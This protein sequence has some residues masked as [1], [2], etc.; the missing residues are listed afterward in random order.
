MIANHV[1]NNHLKKIIRDVANFISNSSEVPE[2]LLYDFINEVRVS[3]LIVPANIEGDYMNFKHLTL[4]DGSDII[5]LFTDMGEFSKDSSDYNPISNHFEFYVDLVKTHGFK[6][7]VINP[8]IDDFFM[9]LDLISKIRPFKK[10]EYSKGYDAGELKRLGESIKNESLVEF[11]RNGANLRNYDGLI[12]KIEESTILNVVT[13]V[14]SFEEHAEEGIV[15]VLDVGGFNLSVIDKRFEKFVALFTDKSAIV[16]TCDMEE[17]EYCYQVSDLVR[18]LE[19]VLYND[20]DGAILNPGMDDYFIPRN[21]L[22][23]LLDNGKMG[24]PKMGRAVE[25]AF[26]L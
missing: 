7:I 20:M 15:H 14:E 16:D 24:N 17:C 19:F 26:I 18:V 1:T 23:R 22:L 4:D 8:E 25:Y 3:N 11:I 9:D 21:V 12:E 2:D 5:G 6:G 13:C 10:T